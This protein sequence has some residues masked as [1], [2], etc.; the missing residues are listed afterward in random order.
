[1]ARDGRDGGRDGGRN[2]GTVRLGAIGDIHYTKS[3]QQRP[4]H[5]LLAQA[6]RECDVLLLAGD[7]TDRGLPEEAQALAREIHAA[8][9]VPVVAV[10]GNHDF[11]SDAA[12]EVSRILTDAAGVVVLDGTAVEILGVGF[13]GA[14]GFP[15]G[16]GARAL[17]DWAGKVG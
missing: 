12:D 13:A 6:S 16:F 10:L 4:L 11:E 17:Q 5:D 9:A 3:P 7:L 2:G 15:G 14:K 1:M 8:V